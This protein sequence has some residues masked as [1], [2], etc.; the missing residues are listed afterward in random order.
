MRIA[1]KHLLLIPPSDVPATCADYAAHAKPPFC[2]RYPAYHNMCRFWS[3]LVFE[4]PEL[5]SI[6]YYARLDDDSFLRDPIQYDIFHVMH[7]QKK[8]YG[9]RVPMMELP[10]EDPEFLQGLFPTLE[11]HAAELDIE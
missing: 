10:L 3:K 7:L 6:Q 2:S 5:A 9:F 4:L 11:T 8:A 1:F